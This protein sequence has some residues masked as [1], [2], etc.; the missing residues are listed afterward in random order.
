MNIQKITGVIVAIIASLIL[1]I[2]MFLQSGLNLLSF[3]KKSTVTI[4]KH[5]IAVSLAKTEK[6]KQI[7][8]SDKSSLSKDTGMLFTFDTA[9]TYGFWMKKMKFPIDIVFINDNKITTIFKNVTPPPSGATIPDDKL[10]IY[11]PTIPS[12]RVLELPSG[13]ADTYSLKV[14]DTVEFKL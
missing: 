10:P 1:V 6:E 11:T 14:G 4:N 9:D 3:T 8:L 12:N 7:G 13:A 5:T 2:Y